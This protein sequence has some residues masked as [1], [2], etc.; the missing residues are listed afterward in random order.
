M[1]K[2]RDGP[3]WV[4]WYEG[5]RLELPIH[6]VKAVNPAHTP[7]EFEL[8]LNES[9]DG[10]W[11]FR[12]AREITR[13]RDQ[14]AGRTTD[15]FPYLLPE[16]Q[17]LYKA[18]LLREKDRVDFSNVLGLLDEDACGWLISALTRFLPGHEWIDLL[19]RR[20]NGRG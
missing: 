7:A 17:L 2:T 19:E 13:P 4:P 3:A 1:V 6:Q 5:E 12:R 8:F 15:G 18:R 16:V 10:L 14:L 20:R 9:D 11:W